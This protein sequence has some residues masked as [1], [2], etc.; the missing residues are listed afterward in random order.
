M[1]RPREGFMTESVRNKYL[2]YAMRTGLV[3]ADADIT[4]R[5]PDIVPL[6]APKDKSKPVQFWQLYSILGERPVLAIVGAFYSKIYE[7]TDPKYTWFRE[8]FSRISGKDHHIATQA[9]MWLDCFGAGANYHGG[10]YRLNFHHQHNAMQVMT[11]DGALRWIEIMEET[12]DEACERDQN[13]NFY[14][15]GTTGAAFG[16]LVR[17]FSGDMEQVWRARAA[18]NTFLGYFMDDYAKKFNFKRYSK[19]IAD[20]ADRKHKLAFGARNPAVGVDGYPLQQQPQQQQE[21]K[22][23][24]S[25]PA[26]AVAEAVNLMNLSEQQIRSMKASELKAALIRHKIDVSDCL[27]KDQLIAKALN[28]CC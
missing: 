28:L 2:A 26:V 1:S 21:T 11:E 25:S 24:S 6:T 5:H 10:E 4:L 13:K 7:N 22:Q 15:N 8:A 14:N 18:I 17:H 23:N 9:A 27:E 12:L 20:V 19:K 3:P 16:A